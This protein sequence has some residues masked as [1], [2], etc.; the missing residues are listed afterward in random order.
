MST[1]TTEKAAKAIDLTA[2]QTRAVREGR[3]TQHRIVVDLR[4]NLSFPHDAYTH[5]WKH[6][7]GGFAFTDAPEFTPIEPHGYQCPVGNVG[8]TIS[9]R[10]P[11][12]IDS[13]GHGGSLSDYRFHVGI[14]YDDDVASWEV[15]RDVHKEFDAMFMGDD[16]DSVTWRDASAMPEW[17]VRTR[18]RITEIRV[19]RLREIS[20]SE[21]K[22]EG[23]IAEYGHDGMLAIRAFAAAWDATH[24]AP[25]TKWSD[26]PW[27]WVL[28]FTRV[29]PDSR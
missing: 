28:T 5:V 15:S 4:S 26:S 24:D 14:A 8:D 6:P 16:S 21:C 18:V 22:R 19:E 9:I 11:W 1:T 17:A 25:G 20:P 12:G 3:M 10:E 27:V 23:A 29:S 13:T 7:G 2:E